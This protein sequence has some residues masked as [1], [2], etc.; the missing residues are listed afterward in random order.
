MIPHRDERPRTAFLLT[1][2]DIINDTAS[3]IDLSKYLSAEELAQK[4][5]YKKTD[6]IT[7]IA[8]QADL[9]PVK[10][11]KKFLFDA[12]QFEHY[13]FFGL[14][15]V[16]S[17]R[18]KTLNYIEDLPRYNNFLTVESENTIVIADAHIPFLDLQFFQDI[19][20]FA[21]KEK[22]DTLIH[23]GDYFDQ[24]A[25]A[26]FYSPVKNI[27][28]DIEEACGLEINNIIAEQF[29][30]VVYEMGNH[31]MH[32]AHRLQSLG[33][34]IGATSAYKMIT[35]KNVKITPYK[36]MVLLNG[37]EKWHVEHPQKTVI[38]VNTVGAHRNQC[39]KKISE[40]GSAIFA[41]GHTAGLTR[42]WNKENYIFTI[43]MVGDPEKI[44]YHS[45]PA[46]YAEWDQTFIWINKGVPHLIWKDEIWWWLER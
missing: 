43:G 37:G 45:E 29:K 16:H 46:T 41:H 40:M 27:P 21:K 30:S 44:Y 7:R 3:I 17:N 15:L 39:S 19:M 34:E 25:Y 12:D 36:H 10:Q 24:N 42:S 1:S 9:T 13:L 4:H 28:W 14:D 23:G 35:N 20:Q 26:R 11:G 33:K 38:K 32:I 6:S 2:E 18:A 8:K 22:V 5:G 31:D